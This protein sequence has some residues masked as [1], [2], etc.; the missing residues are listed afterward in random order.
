VGVMCPLQ[1]LKSTS[2][3][4]KLKY[5]QNEQEFFIDS[6]GQTKVRM[7]GSQRLIDTSTGILITLVPYET[8]PSNDDDNESVGSS[9]S[10]FSTPRHQSLSPVNDSSNNE[11]I[12]T[13]SKLLSPIKLINEKQSKRAS[14]F[15]SS[16]LDVINESHDHSSQPFN[17]NPQDENIINSHQ[18]SATE[19]LTTDHIIEYDKG[20]NSGH[21][22]IFISI[23][24]LKKF[25]KDSLNSLTNFSHSN[26]KHSSQVVNLEQINSKINTNEMNHDLLQ[27]SIEHLK[28]IDHILSLCKCLDKSTGLYS[29][30]TSCL[31]DIAET[32]LCQLLQKCLNVSIEGK[33]SIHEEIITLNINSRHDS[34][35]PYGY[36]FANIVQNVV[37][38]QK[39]KSSSVSDDISNNL[40][41]SNSILKLRHAS[42]KLKNRRN[43]TQV[44]KIKRIFQFTK[45]H[46]S[47][48]NPEVVLRDYV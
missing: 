23:K 44:K 37:T 42:M 31:D 14:F 5:L 13:N 34:I 33:I 17:S 24:K 7:K 41:R 38:S 16:N 20:S 39:T 11:I 29:C 27:Q 6:N 1:Y 40:S 8:N 15:Q 25:I 19:V 47:L 43:T 22:Q 4:K 21:G 30:L 28:Y 46:A 35:K 32:I 26:R 18:D 48:N 45:L 12:E 10:S 9:R 36:D 2:R 3:E